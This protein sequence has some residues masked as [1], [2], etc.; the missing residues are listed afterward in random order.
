VLEELDVDPPF[1]AALRAS[2]AHCLPTPPATLL[3]LAACEERTAACYENA[4]SL[5]WRDAGTLLATVGLTAHA[6]GLQAA[7]LGVTGEP[8]ISKTVWSMSVFGVGA[9]NLA[10]PAGVR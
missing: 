10:Q 1:A 7:T 5:V 3:W 9:M 8:L 6:M 4:E 2:A